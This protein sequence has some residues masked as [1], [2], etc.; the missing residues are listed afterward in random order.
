MSMSSCLCTRNRDSCIGETNQILTVMTGLAVYTRLSETD[1]PVHAQLGHLREVVGAARPA[2]SPTFRGALLKPRP[3]NRNRNRKRS[4]DFLVLGAGA[5]RAKY[6]KA[7]REAAIE[8]LAHGW[9]GARAR[10]RADTRQRG[11]RPRC[12]AEACCNGSMQRACRECAVT[13]AVADRSEANAF[14]A[15]GCVRRSPV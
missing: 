2:C 4:L 9:G 5:A 11:W 10:R 7:V 6:P 12:R 14:G 15:G 8:G 13:S 1:S 3:D